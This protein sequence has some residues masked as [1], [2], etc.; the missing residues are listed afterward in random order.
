MSEAALQTSGPGSVAGWND[1]VWSSERLT[2]ALSE[3]PDPELDDTSDEGD[4]TCAQVVSAA[5]ATVIAGSFGVQ[6]AERRGFDLLR[7]LA[8]IVMR[9]A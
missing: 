3:L 8:A 5:G 4:V 9:R 7:R 2:M 6:F 1:A